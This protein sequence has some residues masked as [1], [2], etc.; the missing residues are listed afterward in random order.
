MSSGTNLPGL[1]LKHTV[2]LISVANPTS[3][4][5]GVAEQ[6][7]QTDTIIYVQVTDSDSKSYYNRTIENHLKAQEKE[8]KKKYLHVCQE[9]HKNFAPFFMAVNGVFGC[10]A[11]LL[12]KQLACVFSKN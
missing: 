5:A 1:V 4:M 7:C 11:Q 8:K 2:T 9:N 12:M 6:Q 10:K 3:K